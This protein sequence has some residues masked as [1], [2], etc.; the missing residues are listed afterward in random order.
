MSME[1]LNEI[2]I[3]SSTKE[4]TESLFISGFIEKIIVANR[5]CQIILNKFE[6]I[7]TET[8]YVLHN[9]LSELKEND[10]SYSLE[11]A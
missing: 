9:L 11:N 8:T 10:L 6:T 5:N 2:E 1:I 3:S 7:N 4:M